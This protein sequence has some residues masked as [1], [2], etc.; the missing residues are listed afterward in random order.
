MWSTTM[1]TDGGADRRRGSAVQTVAP[2]R[3]SPTVQR[4]RRSPR[5]GRMVDLRRRTAAADGG[6]I[7]A[8]AVT[9]VME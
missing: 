8:M 7:Y 9:A 5:P 2:E 4:I 1:T 6:V 3:R